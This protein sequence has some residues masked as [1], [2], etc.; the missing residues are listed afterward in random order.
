MKNLFSEIGY[1]GSTNQKVPHTIGAQLGVHS[2]R[3][4][5]TCAPDTAVPLERWL[6]REISIE[7]SKVQ[8]QNDSSF[9]REL[10]ISIHEV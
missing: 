5:K 6:A 1:K 7:M 10:L 9:D 2:M 4:I 3:A 8:P